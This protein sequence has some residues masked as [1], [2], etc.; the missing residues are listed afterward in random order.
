M[1]MGAATV[2]DHVLAGIATYTAKF[3]ARTLPTGA[4]ARPTIETVTGAVTLE[5]MDVIVMGRTQLVFVSFCGADF[6]WSEITE[7]KA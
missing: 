2:L 7:N 5:S 1:S 4:D 3:T 6:D